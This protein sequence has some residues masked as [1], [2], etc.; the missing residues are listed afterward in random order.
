MAASSGWPTSSAPV[1]ESS[2]QNPLQTQQWSNSKPTWVPTTPTTVAPTTTTQAA[3]YVC[4]LRIWRDPFN[5]FDNSSNVLLS[6]QDCTQNPDLSGLN[7]NGT[8][9]PTAA[10]Y[11]CYRP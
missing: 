10:S 5:G 6:T 1:V 3:D 11:D 9:G 4:V 7:C 8:A 2:C